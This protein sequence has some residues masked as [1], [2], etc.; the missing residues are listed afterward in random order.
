MPEL[1]EKWTGAVVLFSGDQASPCKNR[2]MRDIAG[3]VGSGN[4]I[5]RNCSASGGSA[6]RALFSGG[7]VPL[8]P[9]S[10]AMLNNAGDAGDTVIDGSAGD[11]HLLP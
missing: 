7:F 4:I 5:K 1:G 9:M 10:R 11:S 6:S 2:L 3:N 8:T